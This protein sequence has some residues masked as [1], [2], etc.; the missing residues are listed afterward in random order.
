MFSVCPVGEVK[1]NNDRYFFLSD[2]Q[3]EVETAN[4]VCSSLNGNLVSFPTAE[5]ENTIFSYINQKYISGEYF[6]F[7]ILFAINGKIH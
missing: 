2:H 6:S 5:I 1:V 7:I 4:D 3:V